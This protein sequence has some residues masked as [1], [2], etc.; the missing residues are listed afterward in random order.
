MVLVS[1]FLILVPIILVPDNR[2]ISVMV[3]GIVL[4]GIP[5]YIIL[6]WDRLRPKFIDKFSGQ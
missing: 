4:A 3:I 6:G 2:I 5:F 1:I